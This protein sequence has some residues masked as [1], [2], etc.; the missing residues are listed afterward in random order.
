MGAYS[1]GENSPRVGHQAARR[2]EAS[3]T[4]FSTV[5]S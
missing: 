4:S 5:M 2:S 3:S 1:L